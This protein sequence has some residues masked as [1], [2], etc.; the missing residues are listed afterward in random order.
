MIVTV[1][2]K[3]VCGCWSLLLHSFR[4]SSDQVRCRRQIIPLV[5]WSA[6]RTSLGQKSSI[7]DDRICCTMTQATLTRCHIVLHVAKLP[8][9]LPHYCLNMSLGYSFGLRGLRRGG[10]GGLGNLCLGARLGD[11]AVGNWTRGVGRA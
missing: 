5:S 4:T 1:M 6:S 3:G 7:F 11:L 9:A 8:H 2:R 10:S